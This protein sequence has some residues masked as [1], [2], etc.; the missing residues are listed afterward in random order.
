MHLKDQMLRLL[1]LGDERERLVPLGVEVVVDDAGLLLEHWA[2][3]QH[4]VRVGLADQLLVLERLR[5]HHGH[6]QL[7]MR[8]QL[9]VTAEELERQTDQQTR[10][11]QRLLFP[12]L[13][14]NF[15]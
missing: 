15:L 10:F 6:R 3:V 12:F 5:A 7:P 11:K 9:K 4:H 8:L 14:E 13:E 2:D 1:V